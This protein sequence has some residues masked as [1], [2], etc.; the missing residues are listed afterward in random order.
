MIRQAEIKDMSEIASLF[1]ES[2][3]KTVHHVFGDQVPK[4]EGLVD[5]FS[6]IYKVEPECMF[7]AEHN[8]R[9]A[10]YLI[11]PKDIKHIWLLALFKGHVFKWAWRWMHGEYGFGLSPLRFLL[12]NKFS[13]ISSIHNFRNTSTAQILSIAVDS[14]YRN[15]GLAAGMM[16][17]GL[18]YLEKQNAEEIKLEVRP[19]NVAGKR[20]YEKMGFEEIGV[21]E[22]IQGKWIVMVKLLKNKC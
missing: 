15:Q 13:F 5:I 7:V 21:T 11:C 22:D 17:E 3:Q 8:H 20:L 2:F 12:H 9:N 1:M 10:G 6:F 14:E 16:K 4:L 19:E 18:K